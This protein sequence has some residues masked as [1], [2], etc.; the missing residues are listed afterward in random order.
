MA[1]AV[2]SVEVPE[3]KI[4][5]IAV[6]LSN[7]LVFLG[8]KLSGGPKRTELENGDMGAL[9]RYVASRM[10]RAIA[11]FARV[12]AP[13]YQIGYTPDDVTTPFKFLSAM[14]MHGIP[15]L[16]YPSTGPVMMWGFP[17]SILSESG[18]DVD[19]VYDQVV[20]A[21]NQCAFDSH[22][23]NKDKW[24]LTTPLLSINLTK[25]R[26]DVV[27]AWMTAPLDNPRWRPHTISGG[28][29]AS[30]VRKPVTEAAFS[31]PSDRNPDG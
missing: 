5:Y 1:A 15:V 24:Q 21:M 27:N 7:E 12:H 2:P 13:S 6:A 10:R 8:C 25:S 9:Y 31:E 23:V 3:E 20:H 26:V 18:L 19:G 17:A 11:H 4:P 30:A 29:S 28:H 22:L 16:R 14:Q